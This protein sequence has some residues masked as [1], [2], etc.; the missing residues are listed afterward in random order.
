MASVINSV[1]KYAS[2]E[3]R[4]KVGFTNRKEKRRTEKGIRK[5]RK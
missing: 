5:C 3:N 2:A 1:D 4:F